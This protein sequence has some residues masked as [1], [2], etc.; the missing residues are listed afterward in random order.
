MNQ[1]TTSQ[2]GVGG[3]SALFEDRYNAAA[4]AIN[5]GDKSDTGCFGHS[6]VMLNQISTQKPLKCNETKQ[7]ELGQEQEHQSFDIVKQNLNYLQQNH[8]HNHHHHHRL[9]Y[10]LNNDQLKSYNDQLNVSINLND[11]Y[12]VGQ[13]Y[14]NPHISGSGHPI[15]ADLSALVKRKIKK[16]RVLFSQWQINELEKL[17]KKQKYVT[18]NEREIMAKRL[19]LHANQVKIWFQNRRYKIKKKNELCNTNVN[20]K[21]KIAE[22]PTN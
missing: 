21:E 15:V 17:F 19:R 14:T 5:I 12:M 4:L 1:M 22:F 10:F 20:N 2:A 3:P 16:S 11:A 9:S 13:H 6:N 18:S 7:I 8:S